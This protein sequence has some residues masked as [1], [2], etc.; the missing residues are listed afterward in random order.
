MT[1]WD[2]L[3]CYQT[4]RD[5]ADT[6]RLAGSY[7]INVRVDT[8][9]GPVLVRIPVPEADS[10]DLRIWPEWEVL[11][12]VARHADNVPRLLHV[13]AEPA[14][15]I[16]EYI[17]GR[18]LNEVA[19]R[20]EAVPDAVVPAVL[21]LFRQL[22]GVGLGELPKL[23]A[24]WPED[25]DCAEFARMLSD[26]T[27]RVYDDYQERFGP[28]FEALGIPRDPLV[29]VVSSWARLTPRPFCLLHADVHRRN[30]LVGESGVSV[31]DWE[32]ALWGDPLYDL[33]VHV[34]KMTYRDDEQRRLLTGWVAQVPPIVARS[35]PPDLAAYLHHEQV[36]EAIVHSIR[37]SQAVRAADPAA[38]A[39]IA[40]TGQ[41]TAS[42]EHESSAA[43]LVARLVTKLTAN[44]NAAG[45]VW[46]WR[47]TLSASE[48]ART[49]RAIP[50]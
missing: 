38:L 46:G 37:Y 21:N 5:A 31:L 23:P 2:P 47:G 27:Q 3:V 16:H 32:L 24:G 7:N 40:E 50:L 20:G 6:A 25:K 17:S 42:R 11:P 22:S 45:R 1:G 18:Q 13:C 39:E 33:A 10:M 28:L 34:N 35:W 14:F 8:G 26:S 43:R 19:P 9:T 15:Q 49:I 48:V 36:K 41:V 30:I 12:V 29:R 44:L 4:A